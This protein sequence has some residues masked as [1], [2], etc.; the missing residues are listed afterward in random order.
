MTSWLLGHAGLTRLLIVAGVLVL[1]LAWQRLRPMRGD[2]AIPGRQ[3]RN[4]ALV[5]VAMSSA[6]TSAAGSREECVEAHGRAQDQRERGQLAR[7]RQTFLSCAQ[8]SCPSLVQADC[9]KS[10]DELGQLVPS[11]TFSARDSSAI[12]PPSPFSI[13]F[14]LNPVATI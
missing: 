11:V 4:I 8:S 10:N 12:R 7:A 6:R 14:R 9:A 5:L 2:A 13:W 1:L 3:W